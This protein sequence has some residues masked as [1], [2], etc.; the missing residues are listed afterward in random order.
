MLHPSPRS[1][2]SSGPKRGGSSGSSF[3]AVRTRTVTP[4]AACQAPAAPAQSVSAPKKRFS[5]PRVVLGSQFA[6]PPSTSIETDRANDRFRTRWSENRSHRPLSECF[7][8]ATIVAR[9]GAHFGNRPP[10]RATAPAIGRCLS[11]EHRKTPAPPL[12]P[13][14]PAGAG[15][16]EAAAVHRTEPLCPHRFG[17]RREVERGGNHDRPGAPRVGSAGHRPSA[18][19]AL[20]AGVYRYSEVVDLAAKLVDRTTTGVENGSPRSMTC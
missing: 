9:S 18:L 20:Q 16:P 3:S 4:R 13:A 1:A 12:P 6:S 14:P 5:Q 10:M 2:C 11:H 17:A 15:P 8:H 7:A 19:I